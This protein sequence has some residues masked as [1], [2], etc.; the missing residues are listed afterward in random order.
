MI[1]LDS[2]GTSVMTGKHNGVGALLKKHYAQTQGKTLFKFLAH[3]LALIC[4]DP[5]KENPYFKEYRSLFGNLYS[6][7]S[8]KLY[9]K[10]QQLAVSEGSV[11]KTALRLNH[12]L[13]YYQQIWKYTQS[14]PM[15]HT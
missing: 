9:D 8:G 11:C 14:L 1:G 7:S 2:D 4:V 12:G 3:R 15:A 10:L 13:D 5:V 6:Y